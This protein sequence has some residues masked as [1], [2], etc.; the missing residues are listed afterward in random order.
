MNGLLQ[1]RATAVL[2]VLGVYLAGGLLTNLLIRLS[3]VAVRNPLENLSI[4]IT[5][6]ALITASRQMFVLL[7]FEYAGYFLLIIP[8]NWWHR[9]S[10][11]AAYGLTK[12]GHS[13]RTL[14]LA[15]L[16][17]AAL[18]EW[19]VLSIGLLNSFHPSATAPWRQAFFD[20]SWRRWEFWLFSAVMSWALI[21]VV[22][23]LFFRGYCQRRLA[24]DWGDGPAIIGTACL[25]TFA[26][27]QYQIPSAYN[28]GMIVGLLISAIGFGVVF[29]WTRSL[30]PAMIAHA[31]FDIPMTP[32]WESLLVAALVIGAFFSWRRGLSIIGQVFSTR[33]G[34]ACGT[35]AALCTVYALAA[36]RVR[37]LEYVA[38]GLVVLAVVLETLERRRNRI[39]TDVHL[40]SRE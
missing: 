17:T 3:G 21:P 23:E 9:R 8:I 11:L 22:E 32:K 12:A 40:T 35:L 34:I 2:E 5:G 33:S 37:R 30:V 1:R 4:H 19:P 24:E 15:G 27:T 18:S 38:I 20:M 36:T 25:F 6:A 28:A 29:A 10:G 7:M 31:I 14:L 39:A 13:W 16:G 26:H